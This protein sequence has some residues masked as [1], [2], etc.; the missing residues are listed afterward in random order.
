MMK[1]FKLLSAVLLSV[2]LMMAC[3]NSNNN[4]KKEPASPG[5]S[6]TG[7]TNPTTNALDYNNDQRQVIPRTDSSNVV[8]TDTVSGS[9]ATPNT[10]TTK[11]YNVKKGSKDSAQ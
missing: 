5:V 1:T 11:S 9:T 6:D 7:I 4:S 3:N 8:G 2:S 10:G